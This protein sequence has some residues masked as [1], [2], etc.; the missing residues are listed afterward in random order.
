M[1]QTLQR[2]YL[3]RDSKPVDLLIWNPFLVPNEDS[4]HGREEFTSGGMLALQSAPYAVDQGPSG[5]FG[6]QVGVKFADLART[7]ESLS[8]HKAAVVREYGE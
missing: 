6:V 4:S 3:Q 8:G 7:P 2:A 1:T 5:P